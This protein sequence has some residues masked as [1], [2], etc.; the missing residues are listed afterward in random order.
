MN[1]LE[2]AGTLTPHE[3]HACYDLPSLIDKATLRYDVSRLRLLASVPQIAMQRGMRGYVDPA[4][5]DRDR[6][7]V[8]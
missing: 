5:W 2:A 6:K 4:L 1:K 3:P 7:S 8:V